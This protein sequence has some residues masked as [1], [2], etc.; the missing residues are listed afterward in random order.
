MD[1]RTALYDASGRSDGIP[2]SGRSH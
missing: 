1:D 2:R